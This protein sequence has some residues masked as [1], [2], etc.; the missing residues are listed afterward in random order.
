MTQFQ[1]LLDA[2]ITLS[3]LTSLWQDLGESPF[4]QLANGIPTPEIA[5]QQLRAMLNYD[6]TASLI[7]EDDTAHAAVI[8][9][10]NCIFVG[11]AWV[12]ET[13]MLLDDGLDIIWHTQDGQAHQAGD[14][15]FEIIGNTRAILTGER[16]ALNFAQTL[17]AT[18]TE[19]AHY[20]ELLV[21]FNTQILDTRKTIPGLRYG[22]KY[23]VTCG[24][25]ANHRIG[26]YDRFLI[27]ENHIM[28]C[29]S[30]TAAI[31]TAR[32]RDNRLLVE[33]EV[34]NLSELKQA[35]SA[36]ADI[37]MLDNFSLA[38]VEKAVAI[39]QGQCKLEVSGNVEAERLHEIANTGV[40]FI[41]SGAIT[42]NIKA[43]DLSL[44]LSN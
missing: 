27:K 34:E 5:K 23:A 30:I 16:T 29:G 22:Q 20:A 21:G 15:L 13:F 40:D 7:A 33:V 43:I 42:K 9:K 4:Q 39:N 35:I 31:T 2:E 44:R 10:E 11:K 24:G 36:G 3:V 17:S 12:E 25:G 14:T 8:C 26:L 37:I 38:D 19:V 6:V 1:T 28:G 32:K 41:S 18:A